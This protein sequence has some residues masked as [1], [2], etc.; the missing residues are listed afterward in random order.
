MNL[1]LYSYRIKRALLRKYHVVLDFIY[2]LRCGYSL[3]SAW[4][5]ARNTL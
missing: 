2:Y 1:Y 3:G 5:M 4:R